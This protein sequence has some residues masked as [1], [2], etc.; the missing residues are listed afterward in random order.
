MPKLDL[1]RLSRDLACLRRA[2]PPAVGPNGRSTTGAMAIVRDNLAKLESLHAAGASWVEIAATLAAQ[3][4]RH[5][6]GAA[7]TGRQLTGLIASVRRQQRRREAKVAQRATRPDLPN[8]G[9]PR[10]TLAADLAAPRSAP[11]LSA[12]P[13]EDDLRRQQLASL[14]SLL[15]KDKP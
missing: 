9:G 7:L 5:G 4:V 11:V 2:R 12:L 14:D 1:A 13:T 8:T 3:N 6:S 10:L 15:K